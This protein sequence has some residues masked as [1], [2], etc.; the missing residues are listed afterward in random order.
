M[1]ESD[2]A[3]YMRLTNYYFFVC[4]VTRA[5]RLYRDPLYRND[6]AIIYPFRGFGAALGFTSIAISVDDARLVVRLYTGLD[7]G[8]KCQRGK[9]RGSRERI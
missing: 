9:E 1:N 2:K 5:I 8:R 3:K 7:I 6:C 4:N